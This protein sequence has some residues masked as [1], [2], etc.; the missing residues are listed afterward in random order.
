MFCRKDIFCNFK[1]P[2]EKG[3]SVIFGNLEERVFWV[4]FGDIGEGYFG[5]FWRFRRRVFCVNL[6]N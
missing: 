6:R 1:K 4:I 5:H 3:I 2:E